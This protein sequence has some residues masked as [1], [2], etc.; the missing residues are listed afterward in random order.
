LVR[1]RQQQN[2]E[3]RILQENY[4]EAVKKIHQLETWRQ[5]VVLRKET[6]EKSP[7]KVIQRL[8]SRVQDAVSYSP[9]LSDRVPSLDDYHFSDHSN[10][11]QDKAALSSSAAHHFFPSFDGSIPISEAASPQVPNVVSL[12]SNYVDPSGST[13]RLP[14]IQLE[15]QHIEPKI[16]DSTAHLSMSSYD[17]RDPEE[18]YDTDGVQ[19]DDLL[20]FK[21]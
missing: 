19:L 10:P 7:P 9:D 17:L 13:S 14:H 15:T 8:D 12:P 6:P 1:E 20:R 18:Y 3:F 2:E 4:Q 5:S 16:E 11:Y 21:V